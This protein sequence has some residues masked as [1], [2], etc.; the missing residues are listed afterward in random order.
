M[1]LKHYVKLNTKIAAVL[2]T[3]ACVIIVFLFKDYSTARVRADGSI[4]VLVTEWIRAFFYSFILAGLYNLPSLLFR[5]RYNQKVEAKRQ[6]Q[7]DK[8]TVARTKR[9]NE[10]LKR[11][12]RTRSFEQA[13]VH[14]IASQP[15][16]ELTN[17]EAAASLS[18][19]ER[20]LTL[21]SEDHYGP[22]KFREGIETINRYKRLRESGRLDLDTLHT[23]IRESELPELYQ[24]FALDPDEALELYTNMQERHQEIRS[25]SFAIQ[26]GVEGEQLVRKELDQYAD[27][28]V[29]L[30][31]N[32]IA[33]EEGKTIESDALVFS[34][35]GLFTVEV[36]NIKS[37][38][39]HMI[40]I[41]KDGVWYA[42]RNTSEEWTVDEQAS[43]IFDQMNRQ[44]YGTQKFIHDQTGERHTVHPVIVIANDNAK[45][46]NETDWVIIR[47]NQLYSVISRG[48]D[49]LS[50]TTYRTL[51]RL[52]DT[53]NL[54][55]RAFRHYDYLQEIEALSKNATILHHTFF[56]Y[57]MMLATYNEMPK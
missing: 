8:D 37:R 41:A 44:V 29:T 33:Y 34:E 51:H 24:R 6:A 47:P 50:E 26:I 42:R 13:T 31:G 54:G 12:F 45:I 32:R 5:K 2:A 27:R 3:I 39:N 53:H 18:K 10:I 43:K 46:E 14:S 1:K 40:K 19:I 28:Y 38:G 55:Q 22:D 25:Q 20:L 52:F 57:S 49:S 9:Y 11:V 30:Y 35:Q 16:V 48:S 21:T 4:F 15:T 23:F 17:E 7:L 56:L 36:K